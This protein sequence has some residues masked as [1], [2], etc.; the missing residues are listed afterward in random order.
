MKKTRDF[1]SN[2]AG[3]D[4]SRAGIIILQDL[5]V[6]VLLECGFYSREGLI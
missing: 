5:Q 6:W 4:I 3:G 2:I 1:A